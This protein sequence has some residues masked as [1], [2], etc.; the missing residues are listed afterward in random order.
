MPGQPALAI[1]P[2]NIEADEPLIGLREQT[3]FPEVSISRLGKK[4]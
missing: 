3:A 2:G 4:T 1:E